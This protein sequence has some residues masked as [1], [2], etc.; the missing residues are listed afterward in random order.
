M[1]LVLFVLSEDKMKPTIN[2]KTPLKII[3]LSDVFLSI[4]SDQA[5]ILPV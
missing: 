2:K 5:D 1:M 4:R 3:C